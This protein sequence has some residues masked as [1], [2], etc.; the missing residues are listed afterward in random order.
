MGTEGL[1]QVQVECCNMEPIPPPA[2][3]VAG[4]SL[5]TPDAVNSW[6]Q[7]SCGR[8]VSDQLTRSSSVREGR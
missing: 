7:F 5:L 1:V 8:M 2:C 6:K 4:R 3:E